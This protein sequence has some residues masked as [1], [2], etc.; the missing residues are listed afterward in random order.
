MPTSFDGKN[1][2]DLKQH[3]IQQYDAAILSGKIDHQHILSISQA[4]AMVVCKDLKWNQF[5]GTKDDHEVRK[6]YAL[7]MDTLLHPEKG[8]LLP[9]SNKK[10]GPWFSPLAL[11]SQVPAARQGPGPIR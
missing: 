2:K 10:C 5:L 11:L 1:T 7:E 8:I 3:L 4:I 6:A 9:P